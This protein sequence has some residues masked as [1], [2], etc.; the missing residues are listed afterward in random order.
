MVDE[1]LKKHT[2]TKLGGN[3]DYF[4]TPETYEQVQ[5][6]IIL[7]NQEN[8]PFTLLANGSNLIVKDGG[9]R[10]IVMN[11]HKLSDIS[12]DE[13]VI[14]AQSGERKSKRLNYSHVTI[15]YAVL[16]F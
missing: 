16:C 3:A 10:G 4:I 5:Q 7:A 15:S 12:V 13:K 1:P 14:V 11:L 6:T 2:Y 9:I 8:I